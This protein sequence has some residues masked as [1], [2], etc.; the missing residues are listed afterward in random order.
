MQCSFASERSKSDRAIYNTRADVSE[1][2]LSQIE[3]TYHWTTTT[4]RSLS[5]WWSGAAV[6]QSL[7][8]DIAL[9]HTH[10]LHLMFALTALQLASCRAD[11]RKYYIT[12]A[13]RHYEAALSN[14]THAMANID[15]DNSDAVLVSVQLI[16]FVNWAKGPRE[17]EYLAFGTQ[18][19]SDWLI[20]FRGVRTTSE[21]S[22]QH[23]SKDVSDARVPQSR[24]L[25]SL[26]EPT[27]W[28]SQLTELHEHV[29]AI[30][31]PTEK[32]EDTRALD[33]L[34]E[35]FTSRYHG[36]D[37][38]YHVVFAWLYKMSDNFL[39]RMQ[40]HDPIPLIIFAHFVVLMQEMEQFWYMKDW[41]KHCMSGIH[42]ALGK[43]HR[44]WIKWP[45]AKIG[46]IPP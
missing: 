20:M 7:L 37:S 44:P 22:K 39:D 38:E 13:D 1:L 14:V 12:L 10:V 32:R 42:D 30:S 17:G 5:A 40:Q 6:W 29:F 9:G 4:S 24:P 45:M 18:G 2:D 25:S 27:G 19:R 33:I 3:L 43:E 28:E 16:C 41:T 34:R 21:A 23:T 36:E 31:A 15:K 35:C 11:R 46:W 8:H 26:C